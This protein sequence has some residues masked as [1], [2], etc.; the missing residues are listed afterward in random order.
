MHSSRRW[1]SHLV[2]G[3]YG[4]TL[5]RRYGETLTPRRVNRR[6]GAGKTVI[7][8]LQRLLSIM[9]PLVVVVYS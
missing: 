8:G 4:A 1:T 9:A 5:V 3:E 6:R 2:D 7:I